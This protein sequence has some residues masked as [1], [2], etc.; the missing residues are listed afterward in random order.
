[1]TCKIVT[2]WI[3][4]IKNR[5]KRIFTRFNLSPHKLFVKW[6]LIVNDTKISLTARLTRHIHYISRFLKH[7]IL[8]ISLYQCRLYLITYLITYGQGVRLQFRLHCGTETRMDWVLL[9][10]EECKI[11]MTKKSNY[12]Q[13]VIDRSACRWWLRNYAI[14]FL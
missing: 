13:G 2:G 4:K 7:K 1:M 14:L 10:L 5:A 11:S 6:G 3:V 12:S 8:F 9:T